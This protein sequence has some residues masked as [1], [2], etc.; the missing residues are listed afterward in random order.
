MA[1]VTISTAAKVTHSGTS[2]RVSGFMGISSALASLRMKCYRTDR[3][4]SRNAQLTALSGRR[5][6]GCAGSERI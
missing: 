6:V 3:M 1:M 2:I 4:G 5:G